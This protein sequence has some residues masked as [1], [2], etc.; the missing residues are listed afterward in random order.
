MEKGN[1]VIF[2]DGGSS[3]KR[4][5]GEKTLEPCLKSKGISLVNYVIISHGD[6]DHISGIRYLLTESRGIKIENLVL[7]VL[8]KEEEIQE[9]LKNEM[10]EQ[11]GKYGRRK[12]DCIAE[13][14]AGDR[15]RAEDGT[16]EIVC[17]QKN[18]YY[19]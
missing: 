16:M 7:P 12:E 6:E 10:R 17:L 1:T 15:I 13:M 5:L 3:D 9:K 11:M 14:K 2:I 19:N 8:G 4:R 18:G